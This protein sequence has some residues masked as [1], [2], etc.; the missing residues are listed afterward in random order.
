MAQSDK[1][2]P[3]YFIGVDGGGT[4]CR[5]RLT[6]GDGTVLGEAVG[7][8]ANTT[9]DDEKAFQEVLD[10]CN[11]VIAQAGLSTAIYRHIYVGAGLAGRNIT[12]ENQLPSSLALPFAGF[13]TESDAYAACLG[14]HNGQDG[15]IVISGTGSAGFALVKGTALSVGGWGFTLSDS[16]SGAILGR[17]VLRT[18]LQVV[19]GLLPPSQM[20]NAVLAGFDN[21][22]IKLYNWASTATPRDF[23]TFAPLAFDWA[24]QGDSLAVKLI[25]ETV[26]GVARHVSAVRNFGV[27]RICLFGGLSS[28]VKPMLNENLRALLVEPDGDAED[29]GLLMARKLFD[30]ERKSMA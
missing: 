22:I 29:G 18:S 15:G 7:G 8:S 17:D 16:G 20:A 12:G 11:A 28:R 25:A 13:T 24:D 9:L 21:D 10:T 23:G 14:A 1:P 30:D 2:E 6:S 27:D 5:A 4:H 26:D 19:E 3:V